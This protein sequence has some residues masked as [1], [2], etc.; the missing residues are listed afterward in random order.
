M[1]FKG[2]LQRSRCTIAYGV[3]LR[4]RYRYLDRQSAAV[5]LRITRRER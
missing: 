2:A 4:L 1:R 3:Y 5:M